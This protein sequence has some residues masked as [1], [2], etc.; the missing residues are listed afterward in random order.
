MLVVAEPQRRDPRRHHARAGSRSRCRRFRFFETTHS[1]ASRSVPVNTSV[2]TPM[3][4]R[5]HAV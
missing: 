2:R 3:F 4:L 5:A 1:S